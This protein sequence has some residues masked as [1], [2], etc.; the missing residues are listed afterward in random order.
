M[1]RITADA[2]PH[3]LRAKPPGREIQ[4]PTR[5]SLPLS[6]FLR[7]HATRL[8]ERPKQLPPDPS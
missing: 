5:L 4:G 2:M 6:S 7:I 8:H 3:A 1:K